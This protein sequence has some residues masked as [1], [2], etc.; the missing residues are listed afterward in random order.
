MYYD[1]VSTV[2]VLPTNHFLSSAI[3]SESYLHENSV[4][5]LQCDQCD[6]DEDY[7][8]CDAHRNEQTHILIE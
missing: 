1:I 5:Q 7:A 6:N 3:L 2:T 4:E 8:H